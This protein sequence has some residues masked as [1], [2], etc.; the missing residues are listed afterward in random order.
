MAFLK[1]IHAA[2]WSRYCHKVEQIQ[3]I[4][5]TVAQRNQQG[6]APRSVKTVKGT[7]CMH[8]E[9][10]SCEGPHNA[11]VSGFIYANTEV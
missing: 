7:E 10:G 4:R 11:T 1:C 8:A 5:I 3:I 9:T 6:Y 2:W